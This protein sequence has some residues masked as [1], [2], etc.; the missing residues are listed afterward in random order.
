MLSSLSLHARARALVVLLLTPNRSSSLSS[1]S[2]PPSAP[3]LAGLVG[4]R[5]VAHL[6]AYE[7]RFDRDDR[8]SA[9]QRAQELLD[10][11]TLPRAFAVAFRQG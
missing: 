8:R 6:E 5:D 4:P 3:S 7:S 2:P 11:V 9:K 1:S 10:Q